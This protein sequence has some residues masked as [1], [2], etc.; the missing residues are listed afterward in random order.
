MPPLDEIMRAAQAYAIN[1]GMD[2]TGGSQKETARELGTTPAKIFN[3]LCRI[4]G[5]PVRTKRP[6][7]E[8]RKRR[9]SLAEPKQRK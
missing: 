9:R 3:A 7:G 4:K 8:P 1:E 6:T 2:R 5:L